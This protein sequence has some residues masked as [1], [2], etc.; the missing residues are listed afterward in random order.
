MKGRI[1]ILLCFIGLFLML[2]VV[3]AEESGYGHITGSVGTTGGQGP[4]DWTI[5]IFD[6]KAGPSPY[7]LEY[8][9]VPEY[10]IRAADDG[11]FSIRLPEGT[12]YIMAVKK[13]VKS[14]A[15]NFEEGDLIY[16]P[17]NEKEPIQ[18]VVRAGE[19]IPVDVTSRAVPFRKEWAAQGKTGIEGTILDKQGSPVKGA[20]VLAHQTPGKEIPLFVSDNIT[21]EDGKYIVRVPEG[22]QYYLI[23]KKYRNPGAVTVKTGE[24]TKGI[25]VRLPETP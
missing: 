10:V 3:A 21:G 14:K 11:S 23:V 1:F 13:R 8:W 17:A 4:T 24:M 19:T 22:G 2:G 7:T 20:K 16:P 25:D 9:R 5:N 15:A 6:A 18:Y 12:Y